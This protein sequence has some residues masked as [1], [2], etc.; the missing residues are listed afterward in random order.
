MSQLG[1][2]SN[3]NSSFLLRVMNV[4]KMLKN[5]TVKHPQQ[6]PSSQKD[7]SPIF[8][9]FLIYIAI[10][11]LT[12]YAMLLAFVS[13]GFGGSIELLVAPRDGFQLKLDGGQSS[14]EAPPKE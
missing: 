5:L 7:G 3:L 8:N 2:T 10:V 11:S 13:S 9:S 14:S 4:W 1:L 6:Q 12:S